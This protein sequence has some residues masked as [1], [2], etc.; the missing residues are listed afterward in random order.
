MDG[1]QENLAQAVTEEF[2]GDPRQGLIVDVFDFVLYFQYVSN[3][4]RSWQVN[5]GSGMGARHSSGLADL[6]V[7]H[8][9]E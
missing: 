2:T 5:R 8:I 9:A 1:E 3:G 6:A 7:Y 4:E